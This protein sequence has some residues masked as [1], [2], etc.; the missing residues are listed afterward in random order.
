MSSSTRLRRAVSAVR[1]VMRRGRR[2]EPGYL[3]VGTKR[4]GSTSLAD[5]I[6]RH[7]EVAPCLS[8][9]GTHY[10]DVNWRRGEAWFR[11]AFPKPA[12]GR[13]I[14]GEASPYYMF[15]PLAP[16]RIA[17]TL[18][19]VKLVVC[20]R[21]P[22]A[23]AWSHHAY[24]VAHGREHLGF[25]DA[26]DAEAARLHGEEERLRE[27]P[28]YDSQHW[29][30]HA[31]QRRGHY[32]DQILELHR[33]VGPDRVLVVQSERLFADPQGELAAVWRFLGLAPFVPSE[34]RPQNANA[35]Y[36]SMPEH[37]VARLQAYYRPHNDR[38]AA[39]P[40]VDVRW[41]G[42]AST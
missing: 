32:A 27:Q 21:D 25:E 19:D 18:P 37:L 9:K 36:G 20:L 6:S 12:P 4:G 30:F 7:P 17:A 13:A 1:P 14:T 22:V 10:F 34:V 40:G 15:H 33:A 28:G 16:E 38:L 2:M 11:S 39:V 23:R 24:E 5:W 42:V 3:V 26:L 29:R 35:P 31:Y 8:S 41:P